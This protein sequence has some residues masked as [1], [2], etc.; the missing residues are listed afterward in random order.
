MPL[1]LPLVSCY[2]IIV[3]K[4]SSTIPKTFRYLH[5]SCLMFS[6]AGDRP[7]GKG[8]KTFFKPNCRPFFTA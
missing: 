2:V 4:N 3:T 8:R 5:K 1:Q 6:A 7:A